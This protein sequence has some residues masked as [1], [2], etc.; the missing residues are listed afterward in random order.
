[1]SNEKIENNSSEL[2][3]ELIYRKYLINNEQRRQFFKELNMPEYI[4]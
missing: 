3:N 2:T 4:G 1:M